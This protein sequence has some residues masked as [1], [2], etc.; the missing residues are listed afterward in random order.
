MDMQNKLKSS[1]VYANWRANEGTNPY[2]GLLFGNTRDLK[3]T[4][5]KD[6]N[7]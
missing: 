5:D 7:H 6:Q 4:E 1:K 2:N 3:C